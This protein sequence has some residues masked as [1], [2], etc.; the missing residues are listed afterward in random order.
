MKEKYRA[1]LYVIEYNETDPFTK[2]LIILL[3]NKKQY[4]ISSWRAKEIVPQIRRAD[5]HVL[6]SQEGLVK[7]AKKR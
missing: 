1:F 2:K 6:S 7:E 3:D 5:I 4:L